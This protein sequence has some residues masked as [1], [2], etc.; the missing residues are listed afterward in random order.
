MGLCVFPM[1]QLFPFQACTTRLLSQDPSPPPSPSVCRA[2]AM[3]TCGGAQREACEWVRVPLSVGREWHILTL[4]QP[5]P[6]A[7]DED[8][9]LKS[10]Y[11]ACWSVFPRSRLT[12]ACMLPLFGGPF[13]QLQ[14]NWLQ[15]C[16][17]KA[18]TRNFPDPHSMLTINYSEVFD[19]PYFLHLLTL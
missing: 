2:I 12:C 11:P 5:G 7:L 9:S 14:V 19:Y 15:L 17:S 18:E 4:L 8:F 3:A 16:T 10:S 6:I 13:I 1:W